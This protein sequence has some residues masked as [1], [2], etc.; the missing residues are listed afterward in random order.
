MDSQDAGGQVMRRRTL[1]MGLGFSLA[2]EIKI[3]IPS[4][5]APLLFV[6]GVAAAAGVIAVALMEGGGR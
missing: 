1:L 5:T 2:L 6:A 4:A 3:L